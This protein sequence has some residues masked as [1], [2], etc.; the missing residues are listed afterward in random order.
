MSLRSNTYIETYNYFKKYDVKKGDYVPYNGS[1]FAYGDTSKYPSIKDEKGNVYY[2]VIDVSRQAV[3]V[4]V[5]EN[6]GHDGNDDTKNYGITDNS[7]WWLH[8]LID[9]SPIKSK[10]NFS[11]IKSLLPEGQK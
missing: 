1:D 3:I 5:G 6:N 4:K 8:S 9:L 7:G 10:K 11:F 2:Q